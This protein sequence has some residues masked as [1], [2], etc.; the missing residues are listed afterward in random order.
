[1]VRIEK[2]RKQ[3]KKAKTPLDRK[4]IMGL[5]HKEH[6]PKIDK[7]FMFQVKRMRKGNPYG[8]HITTKI[9]NDF[10]DGCDYMKRMVA[11]WEVLNLERDCEFK[12]YRLGESD[13][14]PSYVFDQI[15]NP[16]NN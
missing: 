9:F 3:F 6:E 12:V 13:G 4:V 16:Y 2:L 7:E 8:D 1:M 14:M 10:Y 11:P 5:I 15:I